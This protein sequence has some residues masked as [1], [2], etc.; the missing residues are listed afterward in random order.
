VE[1]PILNAYLSNY[2][3]SSKLNNLSTQRAVRPVLEYPFEKL[4]SPKPGEPFEVADGVYWL[5]VPLPIALDHIN[6][7]LLKDG[8]GWTIVD[9]GYDDPLCKQVWQQVFAEFLDPRDVKRV[10]ITH[11]HPDHIGLASWLALQC[12]CPVWISAG[13]F[14][15]YQSILARKPKAYAQEVRL[16]L[17]EL[18]FDSKEQEPYVGFFGVDDKPE[19][20]RVQESM[21]HFIAD[22]DS[23]FV[24]G[25]QWLVL[26]GNGH[27]PEHSCLICPELNVMISGDQ[28]IPRIS[29]NVSV[30]PSNRHEDPLGDWL[31]S[32]IKLRDKV[33]LGTLILPSH[34]EP[35]T[36]NEKRMQQLIDDHH[37]QLNQL[38]I[39]INGQAITASQARRILFVRELNVVET[40]LATG[41]TLAHLNYLLHRGEISS[42]H[43]DDGIAW[44]SAAA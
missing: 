15:H 10:I 28:S 16:F 17:G 34:Q 35:F 2:H 38:R 3:T 27:S 43:D 9:S 25:K 22:G 40:L 13:E 1:S 8:D 20:T 33:P 23:I 26:S 24:D 21:C 6:L 11:F 37:A 32:C 7:W 14:R 44:F 36:G 30:Y 39:A 19:E 4:W 41:E 42:K 5:R 12:D 31:D 29:S 18:G